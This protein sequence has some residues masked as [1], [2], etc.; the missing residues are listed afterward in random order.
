MICYAVWKGINVLSKIV[1]WTR[2]TVK[3][4]ST[5]SYKLT[6]S[7]MLLLKSISEHEK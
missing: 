3:L 5:I 4:F 1:N 2:R 7:D 6:K